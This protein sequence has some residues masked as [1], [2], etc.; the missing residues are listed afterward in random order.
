MALSYETGKRAAPFILALPIV[1]WVAF[2]VFSAYF[3]SVIVPDSEEFKQV[4]AFV[5]ANPEVLRE[6]GAVTNLTRGDRY[7]V[8]RTGSVQD[9][10]F[11]FEIVGSTRS[12]AVD[13]HWIRRDSGDVEVTEITEQLPWRSGVHLYRK[14]PNQAPEPTTTIVTPRADARV[15]PSMVVAHL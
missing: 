9:G 2:M 4:R 5:L 14:R 10:F 6:F 8:Q 15:A 7:R 1:G 12:G 3:G 13:A 11:S